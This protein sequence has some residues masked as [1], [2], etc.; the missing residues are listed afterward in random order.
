MVLRLVL[1]IAM[2]AFNISTWAQAPEGIPRG[3]ARE[4]AANVSQLQYTLHYTL[5][6]H[7]D[8]AES[9]E[10]LRFQLKHANAPLVL[11]FRDGR[12]NT[13]TVNGASV[14]PEMSNGHLVLAE[15]YLR[16]GE[17]VLA[18]HFTANIAPAEKAITRFEIGRAH[19]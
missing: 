6:P 2:A 14:S 7:S 17:N 1:V 19:V 3:L 4:R 10:S 16:V 9:T 8:H 18:I 5:V 11:D 13:L 12:V 15:K